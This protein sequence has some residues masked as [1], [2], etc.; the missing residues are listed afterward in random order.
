MKTLALWLY[1]LGALLCLC[2]GPGGLL[3]LYPLLAFVITLFL[4][5]AS[6]FLVLFRGF[7]KVKTE[8]KEQREH[9]RWIL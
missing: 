7:G 9:G 2:A 3:Y 5:I 1:S 6:L 4:A 8:V